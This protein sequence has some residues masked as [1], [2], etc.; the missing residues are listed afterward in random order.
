MYRM[1]HAR[2]EKRN[3]FKPLRFNQTK[4]KLNYLSNVCCSNWDQHSV[5]LWHY[6]EMALW[7]VR[8]DEIKNKYDLIYVHLT[9]VSWICDQNWWASELK[10]RDVL[11]RERNI[12]A[13]LIL[14]ATSSFPGISQ[15]SSDDL[16]NN[17]EQSFLKGESLQIGCLLRC[18]SA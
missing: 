2:G 14:M 6:S 8:H 13:T 12:I 10:F 7:F 18:N 11:I 17:S 15:F 16:H 4:Q 9:S 1:L 3:N 5:G